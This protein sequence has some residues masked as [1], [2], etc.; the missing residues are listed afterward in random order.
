VIGLACGNSYT[1]AVDAAD[2]R[3]NRS[4]Q[5]TV[6]ASTSACLDT[7]APTAPSGLAV[8]GATDTSV[9]IDWT[10][11]TDDVGVSG[12]GIYQA[13]AS[14]GSTGSTSYTVSGL[15]CGTSYSFAVDAVDAAGNRSAKATVSA[16]TA[17][18]SDTTAPSVPA[19][20]ASTSS[21]QTSVS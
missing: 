2:A 6:T 7:S 1:F 10:A 11:S 4:A 20:F 21:T 17:A 3:G 18:C 13:G 14:A 16:S 9:T 8:S 15:S 5:A 12:Y 19:G